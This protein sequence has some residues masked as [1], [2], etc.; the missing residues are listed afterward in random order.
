MPGIRQRART[1]SRPSEFGT[2][3]LAKVDACLFVASSSPLFSFAY[4]SGGKPLPCSI[5]INWQKEGI[6]LT[7]IDKNAIAYSLFVEYPSF[8]ACRHFP[9]F[10]APSPSKVA[11]SLL[12]LIS[13]STA[14]SLYPPFLSPFP[15]PELHLSTE[16][17]FLPFRM[18]VKIFYQYFLCVS[19][20]F[21]V[22][23]SIKN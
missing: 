2:S 15:P 22:N 20:L 13:F 16:C 23:K 11:S 9:I 5:A 21:L 8:P 7:A 19:C 4:G 17:L 1:S 10:L 3:C 14:L 18:H 6:L 12:L